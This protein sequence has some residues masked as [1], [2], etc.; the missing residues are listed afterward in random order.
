MSSIAIIATRV[1]Q[2]FLRVNPAI[3]G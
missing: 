1:M 2:C 3:A